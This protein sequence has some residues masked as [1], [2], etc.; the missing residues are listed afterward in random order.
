MWKISILVHMMVW[1]VLF[2][3]GTIVILTFPGITEFAGFEV[4][5]PWVAVSFL[6][7]WWPAHYIVKKRMIMRRYSPNTGAKKPDEPL[8]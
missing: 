7:S 1:A 3:L 2:G 5:F 6:I 4:M 8:P